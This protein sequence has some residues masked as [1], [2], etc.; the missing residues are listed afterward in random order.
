MCGKDALFVRCVVPEEVTAIEENH[1]WRST[2]L[3][4]DNPAGAYNVQPGRTTIIV[5]DWHGNEYHRPPA[6]VTPAQL[7]RLVSDVP[8]RMRAMEQR[9]QGYLDAAREAMDGGYRS[10]ALVA[11]GIIARLGVVGLEPAVSAMTMRDSLVEQGKAEVKA[12]AEAG[13]T[14]RLQELANEFRGTAAAEAARKALEED[15]QE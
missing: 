2:R 6:R 9:L 14:E 8:E 15:D 1:V 11:L 3:L 10:E 12:A 5:A 4:S 7:K 13:N